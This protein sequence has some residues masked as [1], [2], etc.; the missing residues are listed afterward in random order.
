MCH[1]ARSLL[2]LI[3]P[4]VAAAEE[5]SVAECLPAD[6]AGGREAAAARLKDGA[7]H[8]VLPILRDIHFCQEPPRFAPWKAAFEGKAAAD[9]VEVWE[10]YVTALARRGIACEPF[11]KEAVAWLET[12]GDMDPIRSSRIATSLYAESKVLANRHEALARSGNGYAIRSLAGNPA[13]AVILKDLLATNHAATMYLAH[14]VAARSRAIVFREHFERGSK[15]PDPQVRLHCVAGI[16]RYGDPKDIG[17]LQAYLDDPTS[18]RRFEIY[19]AGACLGTTEVADLLL[20]EIPTAD[21]VDALH[22]AAALGKI[23][24]PRALPALRELTKERRFLAGVDL[25]LWHCGR[26]G[27]VPY[28]LRR[29][30]QES[31]LAA[32]TLRKLLGTAMP[33]A[34]ADR[35]PAIR[36]WIEEHKAEIEADAELSR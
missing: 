27:D 16:L 12:Q 22:V 30:E 21:G 23:K 31:D 33:L 14:Q 18:I 13:A 10:I 34:L 28:L 24:D 36:R 26:A 20:A 29:I 6:I 25:G 5:A 11:Y 15:S 3:L 4:L 32:E 9:A 19:D 17:Y 8:Q 35:I 2:L 1:P 7:S